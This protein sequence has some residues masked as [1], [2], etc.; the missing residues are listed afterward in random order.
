VA[1]IHLKTSMLV[2][3][4]HGEEFALS[5]ER[6]TVRAVMDDVARRMNVRLFRNADD[7]IDSIDVQ[8]NGTKVDLFPRGVDT[9]LQDGDRLLIRL[10]PFGGG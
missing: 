4:V 3:G 7:F 6:A 9:V 8:L 5:G 2:P 1:T 10:V